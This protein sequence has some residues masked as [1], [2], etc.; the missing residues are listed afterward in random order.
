MVTW[1]DIKD[2]VPQEN[3]AV[4]LCK[5]PENDIKNAELGH[6]ITSKEGFLGWYTG[7][8][9]RV[10]KLEARKYWIFVVEKELTVPATN[11]DEELGA[12]L[13]V[14]FEKLSFYE[15][16]FQK[17]A[18]WMIQSGKG[19]YPLDYFI[20]GILSRSLSLIYGFETLIKSSNYISAAHL[21]RPHL[22]NYL[23][24]FAAWLV[25]DPHKF[26]MQVWEGKAVR[27]LKDRDGKLLTDAY[28]KEK[29]K[30]EHVWIEDVY[31]ETSGFIHFS[32][33]HIINATKLSSRKDRTLSTFI[34]KVDHEVSNHNRL[35]AI[36]CMIQI[37]NCIAEM[38]FGY[39]DTKRIK[40]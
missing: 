22:D 28:L 20:S 35:E 39:I 12:M 7:D 27:K 10:L 33:K 25:S 17:L 30:E 2:M 32:N 38:I 4:F 23:R 5:E 3:E 8:I 11:S 24:L 1:N 26:A 9:E 14:F 34:G 40:G 37:S 16:K 13:E 6:L 31:N 29:A 36:I 21:V 18:S 15:G 19:I